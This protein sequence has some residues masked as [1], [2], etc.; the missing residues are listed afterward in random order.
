M[1]T[2]TYRSVRPAVWTTWAPSVG[3]LCL[4]GAHLLAAALGLYSSAPRLKVLEA[5]PATFSPGHLQISVQVNDGPTGSGVSRVEY[6]LD[7]ISGAWTPLIQQPGSMVYTG[8][9]DTSAVPAGP[10]ALYLRAADYTGNQRT[11][12]VGV[13]VLPVEAPPAQAESGR[14]SLDVSY[15]LPEQPARWDGRPRG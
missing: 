10:H 2:T 11:L 12:S 6:Q 8:L 14:E 1:A 15:R 4:V 13:T 5:S 9:H 7:S 3:I